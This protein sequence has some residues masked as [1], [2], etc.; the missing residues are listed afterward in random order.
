MLEAGN[1]RAPICFCVRSP[2]SRSAGAVWVK[3]PLVDME[4]MTY[5]NSCRLVLYVVSSRDFNFT[6]E[7]GVTQVVV[8]QAWVDQS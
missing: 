8:P 7:V 3:K 6:R 1:F 2:S 5:T 4:N